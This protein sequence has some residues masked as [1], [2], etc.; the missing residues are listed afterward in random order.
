MNRIARNW[1]L[2]AGGLAAGSV[3]VLGLVGTTAWLIR[4]PLSPQ[5]RHR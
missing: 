3:G 1:R 2:L 4:P 5:R